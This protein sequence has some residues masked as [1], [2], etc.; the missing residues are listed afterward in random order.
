LEKL[1][2]NWKNGKKKRKTMTL[3]N[4]LLTE[5]FSLKRKITLLSIVK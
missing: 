3:N 2:I 1:E 4:L 5:E